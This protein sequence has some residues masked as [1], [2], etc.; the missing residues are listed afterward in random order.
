MLWYSRLLAGMNQS[1]LLKCKIWAMM[2]AWTLQMMPKNDYPQCQPSTVWEKPTKKEN[3]WLSEP[4]TEIS[5]QEFSK[6]KQ[7][8]ARQWKSSKEPLR[9]RFFQKRRRVS[10]V[11]ILWITQIELAA[12][13]TIVVLT[14]LAMWVKLWFMLVVEAVI[15]VMICLVATDVAGLCQR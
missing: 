7:G 3:W 13:V 14:S 5:W 2:L 11:A 4:W 1:I 9:G 6:P 15:A 8:Q 10:Y 12:S